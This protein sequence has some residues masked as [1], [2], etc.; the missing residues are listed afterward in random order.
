[1]RADA[2]T[3]D[4]RSQRTAPRL[5]IDGVGTVE[6]LPRAS[7][8]ASFVSDRPV[9]GFAF[10]GQVGR[11]AFATSRRSAFR[12]RPNHISWV[13]RGCDVYSQSEIGGEY[14]KITLEPERVAGASAQRRFSNVIDRR[15][16]AA[17]Q[18][19]RRLLLGGRMIEP[20]YCE[21]EVLVLEERARSILA[22]EDQRN[23]PAAWMTPRR[24]SLIDELIEAR[25]EGPL[26][27]HELAGALGLSDGF[28]SRAFAAAL[29]KPPHDYI[30]DRRIARARSLLASPH[31]DLAAIALACG[32]SSH[33]HMTAL[34]RDRLGV[35]PSEMRRA[36]R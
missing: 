15:A 29:G 27:V 6:L 17:A 5:A 18:R 23:A 30:I 9:I 2:A 28:F 32:F 12:G 35:S 7:Y 1:M 34:F 19:L 31:L 16:I 22:G 13:P 25:L 8:E 10:E 26:T 4:Q 20:L 36:I 24:L 21:R 14:L 33:A 11:H 3:N